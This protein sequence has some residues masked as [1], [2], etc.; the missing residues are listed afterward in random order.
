MRGTYGVHGFGTTVHIFYIIDG[1]CRLSCLSCTRRTSHDCRI[2]KR[3]GFLVHRVTPFVFLI[4]GYAYT[5]R[6][7]RVFLTLTEAVSGTT[8][9]ACPWFKQWDMP[10]V[11]G[12]KNGRRDCLVG[13]ALTTTGGG[14]PA[15]TTCSP[16]MSP[17]SQNCETRCTLRA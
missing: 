17:Y 7:G 16:E 3:I 5:Y 9:F 14:Q 12:Y 15:N 13:V 8:F 10:K 11:V 1:Q 2:C 6:A 4:A